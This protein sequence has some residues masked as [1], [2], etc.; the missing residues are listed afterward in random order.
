MHQSVLMQLYFDSVDTFLIL[1]GSWKLKLLM[2]Q[3]SLFDYKITLQV[4]FDAY[5][6]RNIIF[7][8]FAEYSISNESKPLLIQ[9]NNISKL[10]G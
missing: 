3:N 8:I 4:K 7:F 1:N 9:V 5:K 6:C 2:T 10:T